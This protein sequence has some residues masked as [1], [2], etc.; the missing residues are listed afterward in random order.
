MTMADVDPLD[1]LDPDLQAF[2]AA[3]DRIGPDG[4]RALVDRLQLHRDAAR[5]ATQLVDGIAAKSANDTNVTLL[6]QSVQDINQALQQWVYTFELEDH[7]TAGDYTR[8]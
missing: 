3:A 8:N 7:L 5:F 1:N 2:H 4:V 6:R